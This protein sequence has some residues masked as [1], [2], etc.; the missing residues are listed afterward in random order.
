VLVFS[1]IKKGNPRRRKLYDK[2]YVDYVL[3]TKL[4]LSDVAFLE[5]LKSRFGTYQKFME[6]MG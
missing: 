1:I 3:G 5:Q 6:Y 4:G 2:E